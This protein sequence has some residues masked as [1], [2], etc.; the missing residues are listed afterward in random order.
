MKGEDII[1]DFKDYNYR[2]GFYY[3]LVY[4][5]LEYLNWGWI[6]VIRDLKRIVLVVYDF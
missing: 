4:F 3:R 5:F 2:F 1:M 6:G